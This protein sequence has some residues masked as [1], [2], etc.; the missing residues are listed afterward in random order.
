MSL[1]SPDPPW[2]DDDLSESS[3]SFPDELA[4][5]YEVVKKLL[6]FIANRGIPATPKNYR[7]FYD[8]LT[9]A[10]PKINK[11]INRLLAKNVKF[12]RRV[13]NSLYN[14]FYGE[15]PD[16]AR[17]GAINQ[18]ADAIISVSDRMTESLSSARDQNDHFMEV[19]TSTSRQMAGL[20]RSDELKPYL[21]SLL[22]ETGQTLASTDV[23]SSRLKEAEGLIASLKDDLKKQTALASVDEL[24]RLGN[25][26]RLRQKG[27]GLIRQALEAGQPVSAII[28]DIDWFKK[29]ND[30]WGHNQG[31][32]VLQ[33]C[34]GIIKN[35]ARRNADL[36]VRLGGEEFLLLC[37]NLDL[38]TALKVAGHVRE[39]I[40]TAK[41]DRI[42]GGGPAMSVTVSGG[43]A[44]LGPGEDMHA[45]IA[46]A[47][48]ALYQA[49]NSGRNR[50]CAAFSPEAPKV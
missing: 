5:S 20:G 21:E 14:F 22:A 37:A 13:S 2:S 25:R 19:L 15:E 45:L 40:A 9:Y 4:A 11:A 50:I 3:E 10:Q 49:K 34:A 31:D 30:T 6:P 8:Y 18:A 42:D 41:I 36:A 1:D 48:A 27:P 38:V 43:V 17:V 35:A 23:F 29:V 46:R 12:S 44:A 47:D 28:F 7:L 32:H 16:S 39:S 26:H 33:V 24:T